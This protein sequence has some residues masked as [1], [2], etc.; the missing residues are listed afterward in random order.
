VQVAV[1]SQLNDDRRV[2]DLRCA[3]NFEPDQWREQDLL[4]F[5]ELRAPLERRTAINHAHLHLEHH[6]W[7]VLRLCI[8][9]CKLAVPARRHETQFYPA[10]HVLVI[11]RPELLR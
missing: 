4:L 1:Q 5:R 9:H 6:R 11:G 10:A 8:I 2:L 3:H 7:F